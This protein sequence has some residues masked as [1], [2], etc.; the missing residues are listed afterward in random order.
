M[1]C[2][3]FKALCLSVCVCVLLLYDLC[4]CVYVCFAFGL[5]CCFYLMQED[6]FMFTEALLSSLI[7]I[8]PL[9]V[10]FS[11]HFVQ[12]DFKPKPVVTVPNLLL[13]LIAVKFNIGMT[14]L[15]K[16]SETSH[17]LQSKTNQPLSRE[18]RSTSGHMHTVFLN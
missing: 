12:L 13:N 8:K 11:L 14:S 15:L 17:F 5:F 18:S 3:F 10:M 6:C 2:Y 1:F 16:Y 9:K 7:K 4:V